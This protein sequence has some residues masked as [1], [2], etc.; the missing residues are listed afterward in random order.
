MDA[1]ELDFE[2]RLHPG[3]S[4]ERGE[5]PDEKWRLVKRVPETPR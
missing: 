2:V 3:L 4:A 5:T 1:P